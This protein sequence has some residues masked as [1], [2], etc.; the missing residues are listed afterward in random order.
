MTTEAFLSASDVALRFAPEAPTMTTGTFLSAAMEL[1]VTSPTNPRKT[2]NEA[3]LAELA[4][5]IKANGVNQPILLRPLPGSRV[6]ETSKKVQYEIVAGE[7]RFRA[8]KIAGLAQIPAMLWHLT[9]AQVLEI[10]LIEN[11]QREDLSE[12]EEAEGYQTLHTT[13]V[14]AQRPQR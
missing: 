12:L 9:D 14:R 5:S 10:Q 1:I 4:S 8:S 13:V 11:L 3:K 6:P 7:R 2:F